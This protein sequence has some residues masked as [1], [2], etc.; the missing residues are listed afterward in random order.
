M[1]AMRAILALSLCLGLLLPGAAPASAAAIVVNSLSDVIADDGHCT[2]REAIRAANLDQAVGGCAAGSDEDTITLPVGTIKLAIPGHL[3]D[4]ALTGDL[5]I[6]KTL[7]ITGAGRDLTIIDGDRLDRV[8]DVQG[9]E[10]AFHLS[11]LTVRGGYP[12]AEGWPED[13]P[14]FGWGGGARVTYIFSTM[15]VAN[16]RF[17]ENMVDQ[18]E[19]GHGAAIYSGGP[20]EVRDSIFNNNQAAVTGG[21]ITS[22]RNMLVQNTSFID[23][24]GYG[25][26][27]IEFRANPGNSGGRME[28]VFFS[29]HGCGPTSGGVIDIGAGLDV[30]MVDF[31]IETSDCEAET[32]QNYGNLTLRNGRFFDNIAYEGVINHH[33]GRL[34]IRDT[35]F[36]ANHAPGVIHITGGEA[37]IDRVHFVGTGGAGLWIEGGVTQLANSTISSGEGG[38]LVNYGALKLESVTLA[39]L[40]GDYAALE[41]NGGQ[42]IVHNTLIANNRDLAGTPRDCRLAPGTT[43]SQGYNLIGVS[44]DCGWKKVTGDLVGTSAAPVNPLLGPLAPDPSGTQTQPPLPGSPAIDAADPEVCPEVDQRGVTRP[45]HLGCDIGAHEVEAASLMIY[46]VYMPRVASP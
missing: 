14:M 21:A 35:Q 8:F 10:I 28:V 13:E 30:E 3:E 5:D 23:N 42:V 39:N 41:V 40:Q 32:I 38:V 27:A 25:G 24:Y 20:L 31:V 12:T 7:T 4:A 22:D 33:A 34:V 9:E 44:D 19:D 2:L 16:V 1:G 26:A 15:T 18:S 45:Q 6:L 43:A 17:T 37:W 11:D 46:H 29:G 36:D